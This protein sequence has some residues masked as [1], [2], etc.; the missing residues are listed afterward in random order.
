[1]S[2]TPPRPTRYSCSMFDLR[3]ATRPEWLSVVFADFPAFLRDHTLCERKASAMGMS[4]VAKYP[5]KH[6]ILDELIEFAREELEH[7][8]LMY[9][10]L[11]ERELVLPEDEKDQYVNELRSQIRSGIAGGAGGDALFLDRLLVPGV[12]EA[13]G[14]ER[15]LLVAGALEPGALKELYANLAKAEARHHGLFFRLARKYF[16]L[17][18]VEA[19]VAELLDFEARLVVR[20]PLRAAV[21]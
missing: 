1:M 7:F 9:R 17:G 10:V 19:R 3:V 5:D 6:L 4:L 13:R 12:V 2:W 15:L 14:C 21:H 16:D 20:L 8:H 11:A 18:V